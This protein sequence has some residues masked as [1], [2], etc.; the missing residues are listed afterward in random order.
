MK[1]QLK[2]TFSIIIAIIFTACSD[3]Q[4]QYVDDSQK[5]VSFGLDNHDIGD[6]IQKIA[7]SLLN[8]PRVKRL[9]EEKVL[10][11]GAINDE[12]EEFIDTEIIANELT[13]YLSNSGKFV[14]VNAGRD[15]KIEQILKDSRKMRNNKE[16]NQYTTI[17]EGNLIA[18]H[19]A[20]TGKITQRNKTIKS[21]EIV[22]YIF[23][24]TLTD[25]SLGTTHWA[26]N[27]KVSKTLPKDKV[28]RFGDKS[29]FDN[30]I[31]KIFN[32]WEQR[33]EKKL[34]EQ[35]AIMSQNIKAI[36]A[37]EQCINDKNKVACK[38]FVEFVNA[39]CHS[40]GLAIACATLAKSYLIGNKEL[41]IKI[42]KERVQYYASKTCNLEAIFCV[43]IA[44]LFQDKDISLT[45]GY[46]ERTCEMGE[47]IGCELAFEWY[48][49][50]GKGITKN[51]KKARYYNNKLC[52]MGVKDF[53]KQWR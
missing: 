6:S 5:I 24:F 23:S 8:S 21:N 18:P 42:D 7:N 3:V 20:L 19:Y 27:T 30:S 38:E 50:G 28:G 10:T 41:Y 11:I 22:E 29:D 2:F 14:V 51:L 39:Y 44:Y 32:D 33:Y 53:C 17:E 52:D 16:Y 47:A 13:R 31:T 9:K 1:T 36:K 25:L 12:T 37:K 4:P 15:K 43:Q 40:G 26:G 35:V 48:R 45:L 34:R 46:A 49:D